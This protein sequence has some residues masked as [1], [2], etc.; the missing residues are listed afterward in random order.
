MSPAAQS[1]DVPPPPV[2]EEPVRSEAGRDS[3]IPGFDFLGNWPPQMPPYLAIEVMAGPRFGQTTT[4]F[5]AFPG[6][7]SPDLGN[8]RIGIL[9]GEGGSFGGH[10]AAKLRIPI[11]APSLSVDFNFRGPARQT[12]F[13]S[14]PMND[15]AQPGGI[16]EVLPT[17]SLGIHGQILGLGL[18][19]RHLGFGNGLPGLAGDRSANMLANKIGLGIPLGP[20][21]AATSGTWG[22]GWVADG[23]TA[24]VLPADG[25]AHLGLT[26]WGL[27]LEVGV[28]GEFLAFGGDL[29]SLFKAFNVSRLAEGLPGGL[30]ASAAAKQA[31]EMGRLSY[32][33]GPYVQ[34]GVSF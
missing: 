14:S 13:S 8:P 9:A 24:V 26:V 15:A 12:R 30:S 10:A 19:Y 3:G 25:E 33:W 6:A 2:I 4:L 17:R 29:G 23:G 31:Q 32:T 5:P 20:V 21:E 28:R 11:L 1:P 16:S 22:F 18:G 27:K 7:A 34:A